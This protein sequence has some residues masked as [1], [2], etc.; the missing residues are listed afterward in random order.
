MLKNKEIRYM[1]CVAT[2][3]TVA[4]SVCGYVL[5]GIAAFI[6]LVILGIALGSIFIFFTKRRYNDIDKLNS[7]LVR[8][9]E[10]D[11]TVGIL[12]QEEGELSLLKTN[13]YKTTSTLSYQKDLLAKDKVALAD[14]IADISHQLKTPLTSMMVM[15][16][17]LGGEDDP[18]LKQAL[19]SI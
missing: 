11:E 2:V 12:D 5:C 13:I 19:Y 10:G 15:N 8:V 14:A 9:L 3:F 7:Y 1:I 4:A 16:D 17:L 6:L 18:L